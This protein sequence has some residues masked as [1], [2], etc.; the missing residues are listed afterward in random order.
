M[1]LIFPNLLGGLLIMTLLAGCNP[2]KSTDDGSGP[3]VLKPMQTKQ[4]DP[5]S[6]KPPMD[7]SKYPPVPPPKP[8]GVSAKDSE[9]K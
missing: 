6:N 2:P 9:P 8:K 4:Q 3:R 7:A 5:K 1:R